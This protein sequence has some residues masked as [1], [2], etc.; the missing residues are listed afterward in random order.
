MKPKFR[1]DINLIPL[2]GKIVGGGGGGGSFS[3]IS[4]VPE[5]LKTTGSTA[6]SSSKNLNFR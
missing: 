4:L 2:L 3:T 1:L 6:L 5:G